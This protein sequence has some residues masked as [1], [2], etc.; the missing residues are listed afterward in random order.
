MPG[1][2]IEASQFQCFA[3]LMAMSSHLVSMHV[4]C[5]AVRMDA[6]STQGLAAARLD[7]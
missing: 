4:S 1:T 5:V 2:S 7:I 3:T 6:I